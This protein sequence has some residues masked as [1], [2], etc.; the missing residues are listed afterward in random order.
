[1]NRQKKDRTAIIHIG[2]PKTGSTSIQKV[3]KYQTFA[4]H[5]YIQVGSTSHSLLLS[6]LF[7]QNKTKRAPLIR[8]E[9]WS[10][11]KID[12]RRAEWMQELTEEI[13]STDKDIIF[14]SEGLWAPSYDDESLMVFKSFL[15]RFVSRIR[16][17]GYVR[18]PVSYLESLF[19]QGQKKDRPI[20]LKNMAPVYY[21]KRF[22]KFDR[23]FGR[24][25]VL[26]CH[27]ER[28]KL[29]D[30]DVVVDFA[31]KIGVDLVGYK[32]KEENTTLSLQAV[33]VIYARNKFGKSIPPY[34]GYGK[35]I[36]AYL[37]ALRGFGTDKLLLGAEFLDPLLEKSKPDIDWMEE[38]LGQPIR[39]YPATDDR[40]ISTE[41]AL[42]AEAQ[43]CVDALKTLL[44]DTIV[45]DAQGPEAV[46]RLLD[47]LRDVVSAR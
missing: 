36:R 40:A 13:E 11:K 17:V 35:D 9:G 24:E 27:Y 1:M 3:M 4:N 10:Q 30:R 28:S 31:E 29:S 32:G 41:D 42:L 19:Q 8:R 26:L 20:E 7:W 18:S 44:T 33:S 14:S 39:D 6:L 23:V 34:P 37:A 38:R 46:A 5:H 12:Q 2:G 25:N 47:V 21:K 45:Q 15:E 16:I 43:D 22:E